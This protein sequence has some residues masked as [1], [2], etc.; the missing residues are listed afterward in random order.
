[1]V[2]PK[3]G[4]STPQYKKKIL[5]KQRPSEAWLPNSGLLKIKSKYKHN[6][7]PRRPCTKDK[8]PGPYC[9]P[10]HLTGVVDY[11]FLQNILPDLLQSADL[12]TTRL[13]LWITHKGAPEYFL[14]TV[15]EFLNKVFMEQW[16][17][18]RCTKS[19]ACPFY[20]KSL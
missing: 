5:Y 16:I 14:L 6:N 15:R 12:Q 11:H 13:Y 2:K 9:L 18:T 10:P 4:E 3:E 19:M 17:R 20:F 7:F 8:L 1:M